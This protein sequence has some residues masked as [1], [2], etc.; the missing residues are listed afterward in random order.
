[1]WEET[2]GL[3]T[4][5]RGRGAAEEGEAGTYQHG[6]VPG[7]VIVARHVGGRYVR[8]RGGTKVGKNKKQEKKES[9]T[10]HPGVES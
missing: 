7:A 2:R 1:M 6:T 8:V 10:F 3:M 4:L 9:A 5:P